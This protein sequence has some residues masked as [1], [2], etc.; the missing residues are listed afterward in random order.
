MRRGSISFEEW[1]VSENKKYLL[2]EW[3][4]E[5]NISGPNQYSRCTAQ[6]VYWKCEKGHSWEA[7][8]ANRAKGR[9]C[10]YCCGKR[11]IEGET[12]LATTNPEL[13]S[14]WDFEKNDVLPTQI[15]AGSNKYIWWKCKKGHSW[16]IPIPARKNSGCPY[17]G[18]K[19]I[20]AGEN[21]LATT[22]TYLVDEW[23]YDKNT[24]LPSE[25][26][27]GSDMY[28]YWK[29]QYGHQ[30]RAKIANR[31]HGTGCPIC[32]KYLKT[33]FPEQT[34]FYYIN[35]HFKDAQNGIHV[36][37]LELDIFIPSKAIAIEYDGQNWHKDLEKDLKKNKACKKNNIQLIRIREAGCP[38]MDE[39]ECVI[40]SLIDESDNSLE[41]IIIKL[42]NFLE[43]ADIDINIKRDRFDIYNLYVNSAYEKSLEKKF[44]DI[45]QE[46][47]PKKNGKLL[48][49]MVSAGSDKKI[50]WLCAK[51]HEWQAQVSSRTGKN[52]S[53]CPICS[54]RK[55]IS[56]VNDIET[57]YKEKMLYWDFEN[58]AGIEPS[59]IG[60]AYKKKVNW[61]CFKCNNRWGDTVAAVI[62]NQEPCPFCGKRKL[63]I[64]V[65]DLQTLEPELIEE[66][67]YEKN[68]MN[69]SEVL[70]GNNS[71]VWW[72]CKKCYHEWKAP[73]QNRRVGNKTQCPICANQQRKISRR[74]YI[75]KSGNSLASM[76]PDIAK[77]WHPTLNLNLMYTA[78]DVGSTSH[79]KVWWLCPKGHEW[80]SEI[81]SRTRT[82]SSCPFC[83]KESKKGK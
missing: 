42:L 55:I 50:W 31:L 72:R 18:N 13:L 62:K 56:G 77:E 37:G 43:I 28:C 49:K 33:S 71:S 51:G 76:Y 52:K 2:Q 45:A 17:C 67:N 70:V 40:W 64:G 44:P 1:S 35:K 10:P 57:L 61:V 39:K 21:D 36:D 27:A 82:N 12:D 23:D 15:S 32:N 48:A 6:K 11:V 20:I 79:D 46:F 75:E 68:D 53:G 54:N 25:V 83:R 29:C 3:D 78:I 4:Y 8:I 74:K 58:N 59:K 19:K 66:W 22:Y 47:H 60:R 26:S 24:I 81:A 80:K 14:E 34:I 16:E 5:K 65:N 7:S 69:P 41:S 73:I 63:L 30:W 38:D 9:N